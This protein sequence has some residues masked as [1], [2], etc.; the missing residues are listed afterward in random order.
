LKARAIGPFVAVLLAAAS[1]SGQAPPAPND[2]ALQAIA[3]Q[4][5]EGKRLFRDGKRLHDPAML[6]R[7]YFDFKAAYAVYQGKG[8]LLNLIDSELATN[9]ALDAMKHLREFMKANG[10]PGE[11][12]EYGRAFSEEW[13][14]AFAGTGHIVIETEPSLRIVVDGKDEAGITPLADPIDVTPGHHVV[15]AS[16]A[17]TL[18][19]EADV[20]AGAT[21]HV[22]LLAVSRPS[23]PAPAAASTSAPEVT[24][25]PA[26]AEPTTPDRP[27]FWTGRRVWGLGVAAGGVLSIGLGAFFAVQTHNDATRATSILNGLGPSACASAQ[28]AQCQQL[29]SAHDDQSRDHALNLVFVAVGAVAVAT[30]ATLLLWPQTSSSKTAI[31][32][33]VAPQGAGLQLRGEL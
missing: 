17:E 21:E 16:G 18:R 23:P 31:V 11:H 5:E 2:P 24:A 8:A 13:S 15:E 25:P 3:K 20:V 22:K 27:P 10:T 4:F 9:R 19:G 1:A 7:A 29:Q 32:P 6:E 14:V 30:G 33:V 28:S 12:S 26:P